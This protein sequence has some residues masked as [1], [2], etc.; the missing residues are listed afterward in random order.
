MKNNISRIRNIFSWLQ[1]IL[2]LL[3]VSL[4]LYL[5][6]T[7]DVGNPEQDRHSILLFMI[8]IFGI[9]AIANIVGGILTRFVKYGPYIGSLFSLG[10]IIWLYVLFNK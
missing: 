9:F 2:G 10:S 1:I 7:D 3:A 5:M 6:F 4:I 8:F